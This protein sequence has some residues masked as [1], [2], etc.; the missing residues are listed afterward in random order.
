M[1]ESHDPQSAAVV[2]VISQGFRT[3]CDLGAAA[4]DINVG[5]HGSPRLRVRILMTLDL[6]VASR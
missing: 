2:L 6:A 4:A 1:I 5:R 3:A